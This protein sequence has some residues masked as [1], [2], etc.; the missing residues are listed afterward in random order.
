VK[1][2]NGFVSNSSSSSFVILGA[3]VSPQSLSEADIVDHDIRI[4]GKSLSDGFDLISLTPTMFSYAKKNQYLLNQPW[5]KVEK[6]FGDG[7][8]DTF[9]IPADAVGKEI[10]YI[11]VDEHS[12]SSLEY[13]Q[14]RYDEEND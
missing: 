2:R 6:M 12:S 4:W 13:L 11:E 3:T 8:K 9:T 10:M 7:Y 5:V 1:I 14:D